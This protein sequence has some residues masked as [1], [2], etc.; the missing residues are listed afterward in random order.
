MRSD[1]YTTSLLPLGNDGVLQDGEDWYE[2]PDEKGILFHPSGRY[3]YDE[4]NEHFLSIYVSIY[5]KS[6]W[7]NVF[8]S[9][10]GKKRYMG[11]AALEAFEGER[12]KYKE[13]SDHKNHVRTDNSKENLRRCHSLFNNRFRLPF[14]V[15]EVTKTQG[16][17]YQEG[18]YIATVRVFTPGERR[19]S[20]AT[21][22][23]F[24]VSQHGDEKALQLAKE[25]RNKHK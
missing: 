14:N 16:V 10:R 17:T 15:S 7:Q 20:K 11:R 9:I 6:G 13:Q 4:D 5:K 1:L 24:Y 8:V 3:V 22:K 18:R 12:L 2:H 23:C 19:I 21:S 25:W